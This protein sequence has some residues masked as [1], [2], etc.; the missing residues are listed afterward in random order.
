MDGVGGEGGKDTPLWPLQGHAAGQRM[1][2]GPA[3]MNRQYNFKSAL[4]R[5]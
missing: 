3:V 1:V 4:N 5:V 2:F